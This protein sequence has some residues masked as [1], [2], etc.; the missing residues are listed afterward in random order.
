MLSSIEVEV[1]LQGDAIAPIRNLAPLSQWAQWLRCWL[2]IL[3]VNLSPIHTYELSIQFIGDRDIQA[4]NHQ[5]RD[6]NRP[7]DVLAFATLDDPTPTPAEALA[8]D[9]LYLGDVVISVDTAL[10]Q[11]QA[12]GHTLQEEVLWLLAHGVLHLLGW[13]HPN[14]IALHHMWQQQQQLLQGIGVNLATSA[15]T[16]EAGYSSDSNKI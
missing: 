7:T 11:S 10:R 2:Q 4:L 16:Q 3:R 12:H 13:D 6:Q 9:P 1:S 14:E 15:Y 5:Y 8:Q